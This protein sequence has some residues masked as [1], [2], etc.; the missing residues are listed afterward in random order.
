MADSHASSAGHPVSVLSNGDLGWIQIASFVTNGLLFAACA[1]GM[2][3]A[4]R[5][6]RV[7]AHP[8]PSA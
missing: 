1:V 5:G 4:L 6:G 2:R 3:R 7:G 8:A